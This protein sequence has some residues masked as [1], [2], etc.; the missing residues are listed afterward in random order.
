MVT[1]G[2]SPRN[3]HV[4]QIVVRGSPL[5]R[6]TLWI[7]RRA[8]N[9]AKDHCDNRSESPD[10]VLCYRDTQRRSIQ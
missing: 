8:I 9:R 2:S 4:V 3:G 1:P 7:H 10:F 5:L 6:Y